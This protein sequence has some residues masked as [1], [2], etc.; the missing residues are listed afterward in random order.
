MSASNTQNISCTDIDAL[1]TDLVKHF[2]EDRFLRKL[3]KGAMRVARDKRNPIKGNLVAGELRE[4]I[5]H[6][7]HSLSPEEDVRNCVWFQQAADTSTVTRR[8]R[9]NY[10]AHSG[11][12]DTFVEDTLKLDVRQFVHPLLDGVDALSNLITHKAQ[13]GSTGFPGSPP[14]RDRG[15]SGS[16]GFQPAGRP[17]GLEAHLPGIRRPQLELCA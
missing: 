5:G 10:I 15:P 8:Q 14:S 3:V 7:L 2:P 1:R 16:A 17:C 4:V 6:V 9:A 11:L 12:P 13:V